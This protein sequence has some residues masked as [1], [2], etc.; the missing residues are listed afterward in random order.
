MVYT[1]TRGI[2]LGLWT[3]TGL[4]FLTA[5][6]LPGSAVGQLAGPLL[7]AIAV[8]WTATAL[9]RASA[10]AYERNR[11]GITSATLLRFYTLTLVGTLVALTIAVTIVH[12][13][14]RRSFLF[15]GFVALCAVALGRPMLG[16]RND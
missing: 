2:T 16:G 15:A 5:A 10:S 7:L 6:V 12:T 3:L 4:A 8:G 11:K 14:D 1:L 9:P 13:G